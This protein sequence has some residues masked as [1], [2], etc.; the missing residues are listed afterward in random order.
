VDYLRGADRCLYLVAAHLIPGILRWIDQGGL[1][2]AEIPP[3][4]SA[5]LADLPERYA[6]RAMDLA[7]A[8]PVWLG[9]VREM[10]ESLTLDH[11]DFAVYRD[12]SGR[13]FIDLLLLHGP[14]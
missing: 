14:A 9:D 10:R 12:G 1:P 5:R 6:D 2:V 3:T 13:A 11:A 7:D 8:S 4:A